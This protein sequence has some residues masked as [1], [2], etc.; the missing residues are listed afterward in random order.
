[1]S[2][3]ADVDLSTRIGEWLPT[4]LFLLTMYAEDPEAVYDLLVPGMPLFDAMPVDLIAAWLAVVDMV[5]SVGD[6]GP[7]QL[8]AL[9]VNVGA[10]LVSDPPTPNES[11]TP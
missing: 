9:M 2:N 1:M 3:A 8:K 7:D 10:A 5:C 4:L 11:E 6:V